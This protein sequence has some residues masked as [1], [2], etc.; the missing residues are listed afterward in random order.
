MS[1]GNL[2]GSAIP[3]GWYHD[4]LNPQTSVRYWDGTSWTQH[5]QRIPDSPLTTDPEQTSVVT[6]TAG[7]H[8][9]NIGAERSPDVPTLGDDRIGPPGWDRPTGPTHRRQVPSPE[10]TGSQGWYP[11]PRDRSQERHWNGSS[12][13]DKYRRVSMT[14]PFLAGSPSPADNQP[15]SVPW[16]P[17]HRALSALHTQLKQR[18]VL[19]EKAAHQSGPP[20]DRQLRNALILLATSAV[21]VVIG[22]VGERLGMF[23]EETSAAPTSAAA[24]PSLSATSTPSPTSTPSV[25]EPAPGAT[26]ETETPALANLE[27]ELLAMQITWSQMSRSDRRDFCVAYTL[28]GD[29]AWDVFDEQTNSAVSKEAYLTFFGERC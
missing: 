5:T 15:N 6:T 20:G 1:T 7:V 21:L 9:Q 28:G 11:D 18:G 24:S 25:T 29:D 14:D 2:G 22:A 13:D 10:Q 3:A 16:L 12:W 19:P 23:P 27:Q 4:P 17:G 26:Q 8:R